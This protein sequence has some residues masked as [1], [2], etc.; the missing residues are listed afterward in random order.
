MP[1]ALHVLVGASS[2][3]QLAHWATFRCPHRDVMIKAACRLAPVVASSKDQSGHLQVPARTTWYVKAVCCVHCLGLVGASFTEFNDVSRTSRRLTDVT[4]SHGRHDVSRTSR[5]L[6][7][8][9]TSHGHHDVSRTS[10]R[11]GRHDVS[12]KS[13]CLTEVTTSP[14]RHDVSRTSRRLTDVTASHEGHD[15]SR[16]SRRLTEVTTSLGRPDV[17]RT[18]QGLRNVTTSL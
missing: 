3:G 5:R 2:T 18:S 14:G 16:A 11:H 17:S 9:T 13:R 8:V 12:R 10:R 7:D 1:F 15:V 4:T 6:I